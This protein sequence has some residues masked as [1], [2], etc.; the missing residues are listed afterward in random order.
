MNQ[1]TKLITVFISVIALALMLGL[2]IESDIKKQKTEMILNLLEC[3][4][5]VDDIEWCSNK[6]LN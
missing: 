3:F 6:F 4:E 1:E 5:K 2:W